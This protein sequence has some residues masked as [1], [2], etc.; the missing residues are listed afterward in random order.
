K[1]WERIRI[2]RPDPNLCGISRCSGHYT[3]TVKKDE[4]SRRTD[5]TQIQEIPGNGIVT[6]VRVAG[7][8]IRVEKLRKLV[9]SVRQV[10]GCRELQFRRRCFEDRRRRLR[11]ARC[12]AGPGNHNFAETRFRCL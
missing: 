5:T 12:Q 4:T 6:I 1:L 10:A 11:S 9:Q 2:N 3:L 8:T 7:W